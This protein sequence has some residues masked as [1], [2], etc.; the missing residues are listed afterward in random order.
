MLHANIVENALVLDL[1]GA[2]AFFAR[3]R[4]LRIPRERIHRAFV[5]Q[6]SFAI[7]ASPRVP[8]PGWVGPR[9]RNGV[10]GLRDSAQLWCT[11][12]GATVV[13]IYLS[14][15]PFHRVVY[16]VPDPAEQ[17]ALINQWLNHQSTH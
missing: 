3:R 8:C 17:A 16:E 7:E 5:V 2:T 15:V 11:G 1:T 10:F 6:K 12:T 14:G 13:A 4:Q 9:S